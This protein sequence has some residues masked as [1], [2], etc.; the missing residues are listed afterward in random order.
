MM[1]LILPLLILVWFTYGR[2]CSSAQQYG[3]HVKAAFDVYLPPLANK[4]G[5]VLSSDV[6]KN[7]KFWTAFS[8][9]MIYRDRLALT[10]VVGA[11]LQPSLPPESDEEQANTV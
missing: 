3:E 11:G 8:E 10:D 2:A 5:Y 4:L 7:R 1:W 9:I 6:D